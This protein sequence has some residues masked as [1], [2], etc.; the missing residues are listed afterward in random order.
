[1][2]K[3]IRVAVLAQEDSFNIPGNIK[4]LGEM[5]TVDLVAV[6]K[7]DSKGSIVN[8]KDLFVKGFGLTQA[9]KMGFVSVFNSLINIIDNFFFFR[10]G[11]LKSL[12]SAAAA[13]D[14]K[15]KVMQNPNDKSNIQWLENLN[16]DLIISYS[17]PCVFHNDLLKLPKLGC[18]NLHCS[19][20]PLYAGLLPSFWALYK[21]S[22]S[23]GATVHK[24][25]N[26]IDNGDIL[27]QIRI[28]KPSNPTMFNVVR[29]TKRAGGHLMVSVV[30]DI[31]SG[32]VT[33]KTNH[34]NEL[35]YFSWPSIEQIKEFRRNGGRLI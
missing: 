6:V 19:L 7:I 32:N 26:K 20:L 34:A 3:N 21:N 27:G 10:L 9:G 13:Y 12:K 2:A 17:A 18:I 24:M 25:D 16:I 29:D 14:A 5:K 22:E 31:L 15:Y 11:F 1:M 30:N 8:K 28:Q 35:N 33:T 4:L 23:F